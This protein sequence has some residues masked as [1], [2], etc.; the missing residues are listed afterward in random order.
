MGV[1]FNTD[2]NRWFRIGISN[3][4]ELSN[5]WNAKVWITTLSIDID[6]RG[7]SQK[8]SGKTKNGRSREI[9][10][11]YN[12]RSYTITLNQDA[13]EYIS[14]NFS[15]TNFHYSDKTLSVNNT[16]RFN[17]LTSVT[18]VITSSTSSF[19]QEKLYLI[20]PSITLQTLGQTS[21]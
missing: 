3:E 13:T 16:N 6:Y 7:Y 2:K 1:G 8:T 9:K 17:Q 14:L 4:Y 20:T 18:D 21:L 19:H 11:S 15:K 5:L 12:E 10:E